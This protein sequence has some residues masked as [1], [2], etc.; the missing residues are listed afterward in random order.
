M[1]TAHPPFNT[2]T[3]G[4]A[5]Y[6]LV[7]AKKAHIFWKAHE[8]GKEEGYFSDDFKDLITSMLSLIPD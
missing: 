4:D 1:V 3:P 7:A 6:K 2:A 8:Q 5:Y